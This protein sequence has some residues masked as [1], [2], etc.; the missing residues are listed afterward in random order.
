MSNTPVSRSELSGWIEEIQDPYTKQY[1]IDRVMDQ[2]NFYKTKSRAYKKKYNFWMTASIIIS[3]LI[4]VISIFADEGLFVKAII[5]LL[6]G[7]T[8][9]ITAHLRL[10]SYLELWSIY[11]NN[12]EYLFSVLYSYFTATGTFRKLADQAERDVLL[13]ET[14]EACFNAEN[15]QWRELLWKDDEQPC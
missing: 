15:K 4:P 1:V 5:A 6:G 8:A 10:H 14:C 11:R 3:L 7:G 13:I 2:M 9:A 12:R